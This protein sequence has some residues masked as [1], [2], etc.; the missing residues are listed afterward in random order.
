MLTPLKR[1]CPRGNRDAKLDLVL[2]T[3]GGFA[4]IGRSHLRQHVQRSG[5]SPAPEN[6]EASAQGSA[7]RM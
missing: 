1:G 6:L 7:F 3:E 2:E 4:Q 5:A